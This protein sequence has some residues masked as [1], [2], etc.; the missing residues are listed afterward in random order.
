MPYCEVDRYQSGDKWEGV[1]LFYRRYGR[2]ATKVLL[3]VGT[4]QLP[5]GYLL[6]SRPATSSSLRN[7]S[8]FLSLV[9]QDWRGRTTRGACR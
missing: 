5:P 1:R 6:R 8:L 2:G 7:G 3:V 4:R 9:Y